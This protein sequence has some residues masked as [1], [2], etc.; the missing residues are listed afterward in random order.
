[1]KTCN[2]CGESKPPEEYNARKCRGKPGFLEP[3]CRPCQN[4]RGREVYRRR[5]AAGYRRSANYRHAEYVRRQY[6]LSPGEY[7]QMLTTQG[8]VCAL[9]SQP[10]ADGQRL[11][12]D[13]CHKTG[14]V[15]AL[16]CLR[17]NGGLGCFQD[18]AELMRLAARYVE[19]FRG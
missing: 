10:P 3:W 17:C 13:H 4:E 8:G 15:R 11:A 16:L 6:G 2:R 19:H 7:E 12:V 14:D 5:K 18:G 1:M 9:C